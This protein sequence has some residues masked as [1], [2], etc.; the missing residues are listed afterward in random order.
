MK[1]SEGQALSFN[2]LNKFTK[3]R[4]KNLIEIVESFCEVKEENVEWE[5]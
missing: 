5:L 4:I 1:G 3:L 2:E